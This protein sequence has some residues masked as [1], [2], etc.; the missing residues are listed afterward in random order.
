[1]VLQPLR[2]APT[3][4]ASHAAA[5]AAAQRSSSSRCAPGLRSPRQKDSRKPG[6]G[7]CSSCAMQARNRPAGKAVGKQ[8]TVGR[9]HNAF[10]LFSL[11]LRS[12]LSKSYSANLAPR[13]THCLACWPHPMHSGTHPWWP[14]HAA[15]C[16]CLP[17]PP[18]ACPCAR[19]PLLRRPLQLVRQR[20]RCPCC[21]QTAL[22]LRARRLSMW[23][24]LPL[25]LAWQR[26]RRCRLPRA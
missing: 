10:S 15:W 14:T 9:Y 2:A 13:G 24:A 21:F 22:G 16:S 25:L 17:H 7:Y 4:S 3:G 5:T 23:T 18:P 6:S 1:M 26:L 20:F 11:A 12:E 8:E 19:P